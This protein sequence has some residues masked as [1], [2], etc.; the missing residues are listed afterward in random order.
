V[1]A[2]TTDHAF[3]RKHESK[4][5]GVLSCFDRLIFR[6]YLPLSY[7][8]GMEGFLYRQNVLF[9]DFKH[10]AP[11]VSERLKEHVRQVVEQAGGAFRHLPK[12]ERMEKEA[13]RIAQEKGIA[14]GIVCGFSC[15][16]TCSTYRLQFGQGRPR[17]K[18]D[19]RRCTVVYVYLIDP[20]LG[21][22]HVKLQLWFPLTMQVYVNGH[23]FVARKLNALGV[24]YTMHDNAFTWIG[25][26]EAAQGCANRLT[27]QNWPRLLQK[28]A[29]QFNP[30]LEQEL[31]GQ[32]YYWVTDQAELATDVLFKSPQVLASLYP[33]LLEHATLCFSAEDVL[34][35]LGRKLE[36]SFAG[37]VQT[38]AGKRAEGKR[39]KHSMKK[40]RLKMYDKAG[41]VLRIETVINDPG[42]FR[43]RRW[44]KSKSGPPEL[45]WHPMCKGVAWLWRY[46]EVGQAANA[47]YLEALAVVDD[48]APARRLLDRVTKPVTS[49]GRRR[50]ALQPLS[51]EDQTL[52]LAVMR[53]GNRLQGFRN[54]DLVKELYP[55]GTKDLVERRRRCAQVT[56][57]IGLLRAHR[58]IAKTPR[59]RHYKITVQ[60]EHFM[61]AAIYVRYKYL[62]KEIHEAA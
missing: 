52:F 48:D 8:K 56:R 28:L 43:V 6:G 33:R 49:Q 45:A 59:S 61:S 9:K 40:N 11:K 2:I 4:I 17:L 37:E 18:K 39:V 60:G 3:L 29:R 50:R 31:Q 41:S 30:L 20:V 55:C 51:Q 1:S 53:G 27:K 21:L 15:L 19:F 24:K 47:R 5:H 62:P 36:P 57:L 25:N 42:E 12:K 54:R 22:L 32:E 10:Y 38:H 13:R 46:A 35:F 34:R 26:M 16:E 58:L 7:A 44:R 14:E 23:E